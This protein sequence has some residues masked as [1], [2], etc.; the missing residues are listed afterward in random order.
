MVKLAKQL[1]PIPAQQA[2]NDPSVVDESIAASTIPGADTEEVPQF[3]SCS[4]SLFP[5]SINF[6]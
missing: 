1:N 5:T 3:V 6:V 4:H 2:E